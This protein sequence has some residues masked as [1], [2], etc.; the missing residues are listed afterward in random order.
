MISITG[1]PPMYI[2]LIF[3][4]SFPHFY[5]LKKGV[6]I[7]DVILKSPWTNLNNRTECM[8]RWTDAPFLIM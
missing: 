8:D 1:L 4:P 3:S 7:D 6:W 2:I 5:S